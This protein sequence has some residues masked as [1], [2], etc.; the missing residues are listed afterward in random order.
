VDIARR[1][2]NR[3]EKLNRLRYD[4]NEG[5][6]RSGGWEGSKVLRMTVNN[7]WRSQLIKYLLERELEGTCSM[8]LK[9]YR[10]TRSSL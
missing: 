7:F 4:S 9:T 6:N 3:G 8:R 1:I 5:C 2:L 10:L